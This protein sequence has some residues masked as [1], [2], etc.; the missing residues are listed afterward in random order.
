MSTLRQK[1][2]REMVLRGF[3]SRTQEA[4]IAAVFQ[5]S[6]YYHRSP[7]QI[8]DEEIKDFLLY[9]AQVK[10]LAA[11]S[12][13]QATSALRFFFAHVLGRPVDQMVRILPMVRREIK[14]PQ[15]FSISELEKLFSIGCPNP[16]DRAFLMT[17]YGAGLRLD[18][19]CHLKIAD[20]HPDRHQIRVVQGKGN[21][22]RYTLLSPRLLLELRSYWKWYRPVHWLFPSATDAQKPMVHAT[23]QRIYGR[24]VARAGLGEHGGIHCL[25]HSFATHLLE[26]GVEITILQRLLGHSSLSTTA[27]YL[28]VR[29]ERLS[30]VAGPLQL[31]ELP[32]LS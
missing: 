24:A 31:L 23:A 25:R 28:H 21:K 20:L 2:I 11:S 13:N 6:K 22:D 17:V 27:V 14:R 9:L 5:L 32:Q 19:A 1:F 12:R 3:S 10:K 18:E 7:D 16:R 8:S 30:K 4:Y 15:V 29:Q 26:S